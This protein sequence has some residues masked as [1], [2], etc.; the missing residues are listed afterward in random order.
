M[1]KVYLDCLY[2]FSCG[3][4]G[5]KPEIDKTLE[6]DEI[7][8]ISIQQGIVETVTNALVYISGK[9]ET[10]NQSVAFKKY[11]MK[12]LTKVAI[13]ERKKA[14]NK[15][16]FSE[17]K[18]NNI[19]FC[20]L[21]GEGVAV[22]YK[23]PLFRIS[24]DTDIFLENKC[25]ENKVVEI[26]KSLGYFVPNNQKKKKDFKIIHKSGGLI[27]CHTELIGDISREILF[28]DYKG[29]TEEF[30]E[31]EDDYGNKIITLGI[32][33]N[34]VYLTIH[35]LKHFIFQGCG[36]RPMMDL[37]LFMKK[38]KDDIN[39]D[40]YYEILKSWRYYVFIKNII[41]IGKKYM[42]FSED[43]LPCTDDVSGEYSDELLTDCFSAG[44]FGEY[45][46]NR[47]DFIYEF[48]HK[49]RKENKAGNKINLIGKVKFQ[50]GYTLRRIRFRLRL[51]KEKKQCMNE[52]MRLF[53]KL[54]MI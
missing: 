42:M 7:F 53:E 25:D 16:L 38:Y 22:L 43:D 32:N 3:A 6:V 33:D 44:L 41:L 23:E 2:L 48:S 49:K 11:N 31:S 13:N 4:H 46:S 36:I 12:T 37:L 21:K 27:E 39:W 52:R 50:I 40:T 34:L 18:K 15:K 26:S 14:I 19:N 28:P 35:L 5:I 1:K 9:N 10:V 17:L 30:Y 8:N 24:S 54:E 47:V 45:E 20:I 51:S 29:I